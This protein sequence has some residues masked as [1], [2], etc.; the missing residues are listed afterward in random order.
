MDQAAQDELER[1]VLALLRDFIEDSRE[2][3]P[4]GFEIGDFVLV[5]EFLEAPDEDLALRP[6]EHPRDPGWQRQVSFS[7]TPRSYWM[8]ESMLSEALRRVQLRRDE[9]EHEKD[10]SDDE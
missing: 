8:I 6:W 9:S 1:R 4:S 2:N 7:T 3:F 10:E 5:F